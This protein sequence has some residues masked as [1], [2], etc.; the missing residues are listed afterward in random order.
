MILLYLHIIENVLEYM[1]NPFNIRFQKKS[2][3]SAGARTHENETKPEEICV[4]HDRV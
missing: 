1:K 4:Q 2:I 3:S